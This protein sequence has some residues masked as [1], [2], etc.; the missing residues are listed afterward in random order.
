M[1]ARKGEGQG[2]KATS[3][4]KIDKVLAEL[5]RHLGGMITDRI[6]SQRILRVYAGDDLYVVKRAA[7]RYW[8]RSAALNDSDLI[9]AEHLGA[10]RD[11]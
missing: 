7:L 1:A 8:S 6:Y 4:P 10:G 11:K 9:L 3:V 2:V 5:D